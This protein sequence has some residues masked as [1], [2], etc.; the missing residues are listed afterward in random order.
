MA[1]EDLYREP[2][3]A[4]SPLADL[5]AAVALGDDPAGRLRALLV[6]TLGELEAEGRPQD[7]EAVALLISYYVR[8]VGS[9]EVVAER[10][11]LARTTFY[12]RLHRGLVLAARRLLM[13]E[14]VPDRP[15]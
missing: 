3:L 11:G 9:Q 15:A 4:G 12:R 7:R 2:S 14:A 1:L 10:L 5:P 6:R 8:R 13:D